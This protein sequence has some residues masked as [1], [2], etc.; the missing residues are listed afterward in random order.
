MIKKFVQKAQLFQKHKFIRLIGNTYSKDK[1]TEIIVNKDYLPAFAKKVQY[2]EEIKDKTFEIK[3]GTKIFIDSLC[4]ITRAKVRDWCKTKDIKLVTKYDQADYIFINDNVFENRMEYGN[5]TYLQGYPVK[6]YI[7]SNSEFIKSKQDDY[8]EFIERINNLDDDEFILTESYLAGSSGPLF[9]IE[10]KA[11]NY[12]I[13]GYQTWDITPYTISKAAV[14]ADQPDR[15]VYTLKKEKDQS[16]LEYIV[17]NSD[18]LFDIE[19]LNV[20]VNEDMLTIDRQLYDQLDTMFAGGDKD[21]ILA[22]EIMANSNLKESMFYILLLLSRWSKKLHYYKEAGHVNFKSLLKFCGYN[23]VNSVYITYDTLIAKSIEQDSFT[24]EHL[25]C[26]A[27]MVK[28]EAYVPSKYF[29][30]SVIEA[31]DKI[32]DYFK[33]KI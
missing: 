21:V 14:E 28:K 19:K 10:H 5:F 2:Q 31:D 6:Q 33:S 20:A 22:M 16:Y 3:A 8:D 15:W 13:Q 23:T 17:S 4:K 29:K 9:K 26:I 32:K 24:A 18:K 7:E 12:Q 1:E 27:A 30:L 11:Y 25:K